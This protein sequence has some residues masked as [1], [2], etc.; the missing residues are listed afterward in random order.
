[1]LYIG[2]VCCDVILSG[3][4]LI[5]KPFTSYT[6]MQTAIQVDERD[7][8]CNVEKRMVRIGISTEKY[9]TYLNTFND[10]IAVL[11]QYDIPILKN[12]PRMGTYQVE[13]FLWL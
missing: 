13:Y 8:Q 1:M 2:L 6:E 12:R 3:Q 4:I 7:I 5:E 9:G 10:S 11:S